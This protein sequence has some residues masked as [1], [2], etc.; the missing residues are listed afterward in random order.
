M[1]RRLR[2]LTSVA[3][4]HARAAELVRAA[5]PAELADRCR[6]AVVEGDAL[7]LFV[8]SPSWATRLRFLAPTLLSQ[9]A[10]SGITCRSCRLRVMPAG[11]SVAPVTYFPY[12]PSVGTAA[13][14][15]VRSAA[16]DT[17]PGALADAL[18][19]LARCLAR[20]Q[21]PA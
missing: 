16:D 11:E 15:A 18:R 9:L 1:E 2:S 14:D 13:V 20:R 8:D 4:R 12:N 19:R 10:A 6:G 5:L 7:T 17:E 3:A 21:P